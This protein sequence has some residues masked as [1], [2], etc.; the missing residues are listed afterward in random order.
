MRNRAQGL[1]VVVILAG[2]GA[3][4]FLSSQAVNGTF[5]VLDIDND[6]VALTPAQAGVEFDLDGDGARE[7]ISWTKPGSDD[8]L[9][10][11]DLNG[12]GAIETGLE[13]IGRQFRWSG[14]SASPDGATVLAYELQGLVRGQ[15]PLPPGSSELN[16]DD[17][18]FARLKVWTDRNHD[19]RASGSEV[20]ALAAVGIAR[21]YA[22]FL[23]IRAGTPRALDGLG[24]RRLFEGTFGILRRGVEFRRQLVE[25]EPVR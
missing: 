24:N 17:P 12:S 8:S 13:L 15:R 14:Q 19:G 23:R 18:A 21:I 9:L 6:G 2:A 20:Q 16:V 3:S 22:G 1:L 10:A 4:P 5:V 11:V 25:I 7:R